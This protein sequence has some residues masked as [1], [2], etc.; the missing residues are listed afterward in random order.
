[1]IVVDT[2]AFSNRDLR[3]DHVVI[4]PQPVPAGNKNV[5]AREEPGRLLWW[6]RNAG[7]TGAP[8]I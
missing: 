2:S 7:M 8:V 4:R 5:P 6:W 3:L 1:M